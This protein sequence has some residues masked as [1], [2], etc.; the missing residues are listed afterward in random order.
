MKTAAT[1]ACWALLCLVAAPSSADGRELARGQ[2]LVSL[3]GCGRCHTQGY[4]TE[5]QPTGA[6]LAGSHLGIAYTAYSE[7][8]DKPGVVFPSNLTGDDETGL[9]LWSE[10]DVIRAMTS[11]IAKG[12]HE[13]LMVMPWPDYNALTDSDIRAIA[14]FLKAL[15][16]VRNPI[17]AAIPEGERITHPYIRFG[18]YQFYPHRTVD[19]EKDL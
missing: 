14:K 13:R 16:A 12:G 2:Y 1:W 10:Q 18:V 5:G 8:E 17:P 3:L 11:G 6:F 19:P 7:D 15:P 9:G 4:L